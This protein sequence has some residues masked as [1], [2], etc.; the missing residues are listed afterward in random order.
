[1]KSILFGLFCIATLL[2]VPATS[3][4]ASLTQEVA[5]EPTTSIT[6]LGYGAASAAPDSARVNLYIGEQPTYGP[7]GPEMSF[8]DPADLE[9]VRDFLV[10]EG[11]DE[12]T[13]EI[14]LLSRNYAYGP[15]SFAGEIAFSYSELD[16][17][18]TLLQALVDEMKGRRGPVIQGANIVF[19][20]D[21]CATLEE[22]AMRAAL[23]DA[24]QR[25]KRLAGLLEM[26]LGRVISVSEDVSEVGPIRTAGGC[27]AYEGQASSSGYILMGGS[28]SLANTPSEVEVAIMLKASFAL[29]P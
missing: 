8:V 27:I 9:H 14:N 10:D 25:A 26:S 15:S 21:D 12:D 4:G 22:E 7:G 2:M 6:V 20:V 18:R 19:R 16:G 11:V 23:D 29:E 28:S 3:Y 13:V 17:L 1:M 5:A 24:R